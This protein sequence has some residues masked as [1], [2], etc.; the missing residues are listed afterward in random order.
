MHQEYLTPNLWCGVFL[1]V[2]M[3]APAH[4]FRKYHVSSS[5]HGP[6]MAVNDGTNLAMIGID[7]AAIQHS[8]T[9]KKSQTNQKCSN[10]SHLYSQSTVTKGVSHIRNVDKFWTLCGHTMVIMFF[11]LTYY[12]K[13]IYCLI[14]LWPLVTI[15][16]SYVLCKFLVSILCVI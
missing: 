12:V 3:G 9:S 16:Q 14:W 15:L 1:W 2:S 6:L 11:L 13:C 8:H 10:G 7:N 4:C 5:S